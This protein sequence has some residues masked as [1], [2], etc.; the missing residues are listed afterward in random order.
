MTSNPADDDLKEDRRRE[1]FQALVE[2]ADYQEMTRAQ[3]RR[4]IAHRFGIPEARVD[5][6]EREGM[7]QLWPPL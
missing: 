4:L 6:I 3:A 5:Q 2:A 1:I 7:E